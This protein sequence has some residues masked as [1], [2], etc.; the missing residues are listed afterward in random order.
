[1]VDQF[2]CG[3]YGGLALELM[4]LGK[5]V[6]AYIRKED[7]VNIP[8]LMRQ[9]IPIINT[10]YNQ[11]YVTLKKLIKMP[12]SDLLKKGL[13]SREFVKKWHDPNKIA[14]RIIRDIKGI[15]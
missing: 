7:L 2:F 14:Q 15:N 12:K 13:L 4:S 8:H 10:K 9:E 1:M 6:V 11:I 3:W 5:P